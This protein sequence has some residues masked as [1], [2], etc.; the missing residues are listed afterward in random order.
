MWASATVTFANVD[1]VD[2][3]AEERVNGL[4][5]GFL[6]SSDPR[7]YHHKSYSDNYLLHKSRQ[8]G[9]RHWSRS[10][11][12]NGGTHHNTRAVR[13]EKSRR[14]IATV[15]PFQT[16]Y[17]LTQTDIVD[18][19][20]RNT[21]LASSRPNA[22]RRNGSGRCDGNP[23]VGAD[24]RGGRVR[25]RAR[26]AAAPALSLG[27]LGIGT[28]QCVA[29]YVHKTHKCTYN[30]LLLLSTDIMYQFSHFVFDYYLKNQSSHTQ[31]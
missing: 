20:R 1:S 14:A 28:V 11:S 30:C 5:S 16:C 18:G 23:H 4:W 27:T 10:H 6:G 7:Q 25:M 17:V 26:I 12:R 19:R 24:A 15:R 3:G 29:G 21:R 22:S 8:T 13:Q 9:W 31:E 2:S